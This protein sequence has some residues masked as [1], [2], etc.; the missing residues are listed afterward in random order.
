MRTAGVC[1]GRFGLPQE[2]AGVSFAADGSFQFLDAQGNPLSHDAG[3]YELVDI[4]WSSVPAGVQVH[5][6]TPSLHLIFGAPDFSRTPVKMRVEDAFQ[7]VLSA[8]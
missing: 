7:S 2:Y 4:S 8:L 3:S 1:R 6:R 5:I